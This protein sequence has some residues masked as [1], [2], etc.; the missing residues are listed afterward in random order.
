VKGE[1]QPSTTPA[2]PSGEHSREEPR[3][4]SSGASHFQPPPPASVVSHEHHDYQLHRHHHEPHSGHY[5][6]HHLEHS[7]RPPSPSGQ[8]SHGHDQPHLP[9]ENWQQPEQQPSHSDSFSNVPGVHAEARSEQVP[10]PDQQ[11][12]PPPPQPVEQK[13]EPPRPSQTWD[14]QRL[15]NF[16]SLAR[17]ATKY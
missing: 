10:Q 13:H 6:H 15:V 2:V 5:H 8:Q 17:S 1:F 3:A 9:E 12:P 4:P 11:A 7:Q 14:A 16:W